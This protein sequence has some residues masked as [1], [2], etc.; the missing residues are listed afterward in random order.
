MNI[1][2][3]VCILIMLI[4][5]LTI[6]LIQYYFPNALSVLYVYLLFFYLSVL[7][8]ISHFFVTILYTVFFRQFY[9][10]A[11]FTLYPSEVF[12]FQKCISFSTIYLPVLYTYKSCI[13]FSYLLVLFIIQCS[14]SSSAV[15]FLVLHSFQYCCGELGDGQ[16]CPAYSSNPVQYLYIL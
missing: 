7:K 13:Y 16:T 15:Y 5:V 9:L 12:V 2:H 11:L 4:T 6:I 8:S 10:S 14:K 3:S 1:Y